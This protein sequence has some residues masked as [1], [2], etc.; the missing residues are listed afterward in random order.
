MNASSS[1]TNWGFN[2][3][4]GGDY[5][6]FTIRD[7][8][9]SGTN[10]SGYSYFVRITEGSDINYLNLLNARIHIS[11]GYSGIINYAATDSFI[12]YNF[13]DTN[14]TYTAGVC[15]Y[16]LFPTGGTI[17]TLNLRGLGFTYRG[18]SCQNCQMFNFEGSDVNYV[19]LIDSNLTVVD[20]SAFT[21]LASD[22]SIDFNFATSKITGGYIGCLF[23]PLGSNIN[24]TLYIHDLLLDFNGWTLFFT[25][26]YARTQ[27]YIYDSNMTFYSS[28]W[29]YLA[30]PW[31]Y[32]YLDIDLYNNKIAYNPARVFTQASAPYLD[33]NF[34]T[35]LNLNNPTKRSLLISDNGLATGGNRWFNVLTGAEL[36]T[37][38]LLAPLGICDNNVM[39]WGADKNK[40]FKVFYSKRNR[41]K[42]DNGK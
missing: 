4:G 38:D 24:L 13:T 22:P 26:N 11:A 16:Y 33:V 9:V 23:H 21:F 39:I 5:N 37:T 36:C 29:S 41:I 30:Y 12:E 35:T 1:A 7:V 6:S 32:A 10:T 15:P 25:H 14:I 3:S 17:G 8:N 34:N 27:A 19:N 2:F 18:N 42:F 28:P 31:D 40:Q 20:G